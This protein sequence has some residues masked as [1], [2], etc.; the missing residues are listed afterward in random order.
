MARAVD[1]FSHPSAREPV[2]VQRR[3][4]SA[5][6]YAADG[7]YGLE[8]VAVDRAGNASAPQT[9][10]VAVYGALGFV[11]TS[12]SLFFPQDGDRL[13]PTTSLS[14]VLASPASVTSTIVNAAG[15]TVRTINANT[16]M[17]AGA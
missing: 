3:R 17:A 13:A 7:S 6:T 5:R 11:R 2:A 12:R 8:I 16:P 14:F 4:T 10:A 15:A 1:A 9:Q